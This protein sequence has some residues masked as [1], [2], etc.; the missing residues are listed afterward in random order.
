MARTKR[1]N[2]GKQLLAGSS[3][4]PSKF[5]T[6]ANL[7][8]HPTDRIGFLE[9]IVLEAPLELVFE[10]F[11]YLHPLDLL[12][13]ARTSKNL[14]NFLMSRSL[15]ERIWRTARSERQFFP[16]LPPIPP[17]FSEPQFAALLFESDFCHGCGQHSTRSA[18]VIWDCKVSC[19]EDCVGKVFSDLDDILRKQPKLDQETR[20]A[21]ESFTPHQIYRN[22]KVYIPSMVEQT[23]R[24]YMEAK[25]DPVQLAQWQAKQI[26]IPDLIECCNWQ[27][28]LKM[29]RIQ[30]INDKLRSRGWDDIQKHELGASLLPSFYNEAHP[31]TEEDWNKMGLA[32]AQ[33]CKRRKAIRFKQLRISRFAQRFNDV[34]YS[35]KTFQ[36]AR[37]QEGRAF[38]PLG[39]LMTPFQIDRP[40]L[41]SLLDLEEL[42]R[43]WISRKDDQLKTYLSWYNREYGTTY[44]DP[45]TVVFRC[46]QCNAVVWGVRIYVHGCTTHARYP[47]DPGHV[48]MYWKYS[49]LHNPFGW[50]PL[51]WSLVCY[52]V[53]P[54]ATE[55]AKQIIDLCGVKNLETLEEMRP[56]LEC[57]ACHA[58]H[59][60]F[61]PWTRAFT[62]EDSSEAGTYMHD[63]RIATD[64]DVETRRALEKDEVQEAFLKLKR[65]DG[66]LHKRYVV[67]KLCKAD[68]KNTMGCSDW[69]GPLLNHMEEVHQIS[70]ADIRYGVHFSWN[71]TAVFFDCRPSRKC[72][73]PW[74]PRGSD[75]TD[76]PISRISRALFNFLD[77]LLS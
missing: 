71:I 65:I 33:F 11:C 31:F 16:D 15:S 4:N 74:R 25:D 27:E 20:T 22:S 64:V 12:H 58:P 14:R 63:L 44:S 13:L 43:Q 2:A 68:H 69:K 38:M 1:K 34:S 30:L 29:N 59:N 76:K 40:Y 60:A 32:F 21:I 77:L 56:L 67:C 37:C 28:T 42:T 52:E 41:E 3:R 5:N 57:K 51:T 50:E 53:H 49:K 73:K 47:K 8:P 54:S 17:G 36:E 62:H 10:F 24:E 55:Y 35:Y 23:R 48:P 45:K 7:N 19:H 70:S 39:D 9:R 26:Q 18:N 61:Y 75:H 46:N 72:S 6:N 66:S